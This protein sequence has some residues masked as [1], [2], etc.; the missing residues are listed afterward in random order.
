MQNTKIISFLRHLS[1]KEFREFGKF[2]NSPFHNNRNDVIRFY[3]LLKLYYPDFGSDELSN[4]N[5]F[6][7]MYPSKKYDPNSI[8]LL[9][10]YLFNLGKEYM[11]INNLRENNFYFM[12]HYLKGFDSHFADDLF[13]KEYRNTEDFL[14]NEK[15][16]ND[17]FR[18]KSMLELLKIHFNL[19]RNRQENTCSSTICYGD[20]SINF[21]L[22]DLAETYHGLIANKYSFNY[23][24]SGSEVIHFINN[25]NL[26]SFFKIL[27]AGNIP[28]YNYIAF[29]Y[30]LLMSNHYPENE[31]YFLKLKEY[32]FRDFDNL[33]D[34][35]KFS[36]FNYLIDYCINKMESG[37]L[38]FLHESF[39]LYAEAIE[40]KL[41]HDSR[42]FGMIFFR[43]FVTIGLAAKEYDYIEK[44]ISEY[45]KE[46][47]DDMKNDLLELS[48]AMLNYEKKNY[49]KA[50]E[51]ISKISNMVPLFRL[52]TKFLQTKIYYDTNQFDTFF[53]L[54]DTYKHYLK[55]EKIIPK[56]TKELHSA[57][58][59][60]VSKLAKMK[61]SGVNDDLFE[62]RKELNE[63]KKIDFRHRLWLIEKAGELE[64]LVE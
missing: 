16:S 20:Y 55:Y 37:H 3:D 24:F 2:V 41:F 52:S 26:E 15:L 51:N 43:N 47:P 56:R 53:A 62:L 31:S 46:I 61:S 10:S 17:L 19:K 22:V 59:N 58:L 25:F 32:S 29:Y 27:E 9:S 18:Y 48:Y 64:K 60:Y 28:K 23:D 50:I 33:N 49:D 39:N 1:R 12:Y 4:K 54:I 8:V 57:F 34:A 38:D 7:K 13:E 6:G 45:G 63:N 44:F 14:C 5:L 21:F 35:E 30:Y 40:K 11:A 36:R 42:G